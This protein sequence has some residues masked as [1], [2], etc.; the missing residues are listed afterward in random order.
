MSKAEEQ[1]MGIPRETE[2]TRDYLPDWQER[3][4]HDASELVV[5]R[6]VRV[7]ED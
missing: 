5:L 6:G 4:V 1:I 3:I 2:D 7:P